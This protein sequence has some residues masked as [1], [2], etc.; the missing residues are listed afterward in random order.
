MSQAE[1]DVKERR[2]KRDKKQ[3]D[4]ENKL[5]SLT[6]ALTAVQDMLVQK[7]FQKDEMP[8]ANQPSTS[9]VKSKVV[10]INPGKQIMEPLDNEIET[11][12][13]TTIYRDAVPRAVG[14]DGVEIPVDKEVS[15]RMWDKGKNRQST[16]SEEGKIDTSDELLEPDINDQFIARV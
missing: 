8:Q 13:E 4:M 1:N 11:N 12:S 14:G 15:F 3:R 7:G 9:R 10:K 2:R 5:D 6:N 16:S